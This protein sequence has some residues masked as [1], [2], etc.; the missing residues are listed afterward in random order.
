MFNVSLRRCSLA[1]LLLALVGCGSDSETPVSPKPTEQVETPKPADPHESL[2][3][4]FRGG[5]RP[6]KEAKIEAEELREEV[7][8]AASVK[9]EAA[10]KEESNPWDSPSGLAVFATQTIER[11]SS[12][13]SILIEIATAQ[14]KAGDNKPALETLQHAVGVTER[15]ENPTQKV[16]S[17]NSIAQTQVL[18]G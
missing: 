14:V 2:E 5:P 11:T 15:I 6:A 8:I 4:T 7:A 16:K 1:L 9:L 3:K 17:L 10:T 13:V 12:R 18:A